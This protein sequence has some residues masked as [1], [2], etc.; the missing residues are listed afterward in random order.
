MTTRSP[1]KCCWALAR[2]PRPA[3]DG[4]AGPAGCRGCCAVLAQCEAGGVATFRAEA[5]ERLR[6]E[7]R[8]IERAIVSGARLVATTLAQLTWRLYRGGGW[9][10]A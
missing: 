3:C 6:A 2:R 10:R 4:A 5:S 9:Q 8:D 7:R 1:W